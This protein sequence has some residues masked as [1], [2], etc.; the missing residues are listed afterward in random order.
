M[1]GSGPSSSAGFNNGGVQVGQ[2]TKA[3]DTLMGSSSSDKG[4]GV[5]AEQHQEQSYMDYD[6]DD[7]SQW[8]IG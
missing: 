8:D 3:E 4:V 6:V 2:P 1:A 7:D 5:A